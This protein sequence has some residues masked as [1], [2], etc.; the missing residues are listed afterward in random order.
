[1]CRTSAE[2]AG[3]RGLSSLSSTGEGVSEQEASRFAV[4]LLGPG[5]G[6]S[7]VR[8]APPL[9]SLLCLFPLKT[10]LCRGKTT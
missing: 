1:M 8:G 2:I 7:R 5:D 9:T 10:A 3:S 4:L 6:G